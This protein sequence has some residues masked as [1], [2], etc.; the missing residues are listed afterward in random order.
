ML[1]AFLRVAMV[2]G[3][4]LGATAAIAEPASLRQQMPIAWTHVN[5]ANSNG[6]HDRF[7]STATDE[8]HWPTATNTQ[9]TQSRDW[10][11]VPESIAGGS[12]P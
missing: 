2:L 12:E 7:A 5:V 9:T 1:T 8:E 3:L 10:D 4:S 6:P 11:P